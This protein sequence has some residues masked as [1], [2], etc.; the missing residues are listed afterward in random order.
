M[1]STFCPSVQSCS[2]LSSFP[3]GVM[4]RIL[5]F[6]RGLWT[7]LD[8]LCGCRVLTGGSTFPR[9]C[10]AHSQKAVGSCIAV[11][12]LWGILAVLLVVCAFIVDVSCTISAP[13]P[14][15][16]QIGGKKK[17]GC[18]EQSYQQEFLEAERVDAEGICC[19]FGFIP[20]GE[21]FYPRSQFYY[22]RS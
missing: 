3:R 20:N 13:F 6:S 2:S 19:C 14:L 18:W 12:V 10:R 7:F 22:R 15:Q 8:R 17:G 21:K 9:W 4:P 16:P 5:R 1:A 11:K